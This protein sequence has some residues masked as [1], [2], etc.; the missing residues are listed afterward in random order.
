[1]DYIR[2]YK[3]FINSHY[4]NGAVR[5]TV[6]IT[7]PAILLGYFNNL[8]AGIA[9]S[10]G[11]MCV[12]NTDN[13]GPIHHRRNGMIACVIIIFIVSLLTGLVAGSR[14]LTGGLVFVFCFIFSLMGVYGTRA[15][16]IGINALLVMVL[17]IDR[18]Q[19]GWES[20]INA[21]Y[22]L[23]GGVWYT[24]LSLLLY[25]FRPYKLVQQALG[26]CVEATADYLR[27]KAAFYARSPDYDKSYRQLVEHQVDLHEKQELLRELLF[28]G[29]NIVR[30]STHTGRVLMMI[31][32]DIVDLF[33][34]VMT[35]QQDYPLL[36][37]TFDDS[38]LL[39]ELRLLILDTSVE[40]EEIGI[41]IK[42]GK[43]SVETTRLANRIKQLRESFIRYRD[44]HRTAENVE[45]F[46]GL[47]QILESIEDIADRLHT[48]H[49]YTTYD[50]R[51]GKDYNP[52]VDYEQFISHQDI[53]KKLL[54]E[55]LTLRSNIFRHSLRVS[56]ATIVGYIIPSI[57][58]AIVPGW[59][60]IGHGYWILLTVIVILKPAYT[61]TKRR[62]FERLMGTL[63][64]GLTGLV[65]LYFIHDRNTLFVLM[66]L[67]MIGTYV[68]IRTNYLICVTLMTPYVLLLFHLLYPTDFRG[69]LSDRVIDTVIGSAIAFLVNIFV[70]PSWE[71]EQIGDHMVRIIEANAVYFRDVASA[72]LGQPA[73]V[74]QYKL[75]RKKAFVALANLTD[76]FG[77]ILSEPKRGR[78]QSGRMHQFV[79]SNHMLTSHIA[80]LA[81]YAGEV[82]SGGAVQAGEMAGQGADG[83]GMK[84]TGEAL[85]ETGEALID[86]GAYRPVVAEIEARLE[87]TIV[88]LKGEVAVGQEIPTAVPAPARE[89]LRALNDKMNSLVERRKAELEQGM[90]ESATRKQLSGFK[91]IVDQF[92]FIDKVSVNIERLSKELGAGVK[93]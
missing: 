40:L 66:I 58:Q 90:M 6:G 59:L 86:P 72:F 74:L 38:G 20:V 30:E 10:I 35:S 28:K 81:Y 22:I 29:R 26:E 93:A 87:N 62:N 60:A 37:E 79:V 91:P 14:L 3:S 92:N 11:A 39:E 13:P 76:A 50:R 15:T 24:V 75:S 73:A 4:L 61:L 84:Q 88:W 19:P 42:A 82:G 78:D 27:I 2:E 47:R 63:A 77:R 69:I 36:H 52:S 21:L 65:I 9:V 5:I 56:I 43:P 80:T 71:R 83:Q 25:S 51:L 64:G 7:L 67:F 57:V 31:F 55:S 32:I 49:G 68:F 70:M 18:P 17:N 34:R 8:S 23:M 45:G 89:G 41:A 1:M 44:L 12:G 46:I 48:L 16:S 53:D 33:E 85:A 54:I